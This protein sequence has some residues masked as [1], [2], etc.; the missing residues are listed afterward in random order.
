VKIVLVGPAW[1]YRG[2]IAETTNSLYAELR[3]RGHE[4]KIAGFAK[5][6]PGFLFPGKTQ[7]DTSRTMDIESNRIL[8][9]WNPLA[10]GRTAEWINAQEPDLIGFKWWMPYFG[11]GY[12]GVMRA[13]EKQYQSRVAFIC[14]NVIPHERRFGDRLLS[15]LALS[16]SNFF[17]TFSKNEAEEL[18]TL[19][20]Q[21]AS[22][23]IRF[24]LAPLTDKYDA[25]ECGQEAAKRELGIDAK[26]LLLFMGLV[27]S[28]KGLD[29][30]LRAMP[31]IVRSDSEV[32]LV[33]AGEFYEE[34]ARYE[35]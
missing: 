18:R 1:P 23:R 26:K 12:W 15:K 21:I 22:E 25:F 32:K 11:L 16:R 14:H 29:I 19:F 3:A 20:P 9:P 8:I 2:G 17:L 13:L 10:W 7:F 27:R 4:V 28:Y 5:Q 33:I 34:Q 24:A 6:F 35:N 31:E 30:L